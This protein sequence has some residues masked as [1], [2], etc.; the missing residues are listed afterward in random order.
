MR[1][2]ASYVAATAL[3]LTHV[4]LSLSIPLHTRA[5]RKNVT[6]LLDSYD[7][8]IVGGGVSGLT[9]A[10]RLTETPGTLGYATK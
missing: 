9:V 2:S 3:F 7:Y 4:P 6:E 10:N 5:V 8:I 1:P